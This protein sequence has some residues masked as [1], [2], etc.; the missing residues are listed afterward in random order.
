MV[1]GLVFHGPARATQLRDPELPKTKYESGACRPYVSWRIFDQTEPER[2]VALNAAE[3][4]GS[5]NPCPVTLL[6]MSH[7]REKCPTDWKVLLLSNV[8]RE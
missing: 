7:Q 4:N 3:T 2:S 6:N 1:I 8:E 5:G